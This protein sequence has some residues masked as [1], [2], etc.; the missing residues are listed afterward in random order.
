M[1]CVKVSSFD[2]ENNI[3]TNQNNKIKKIKN[4]LKEIAMFNS[5]IIKTVSN[6]FAVENSLTQIVRANF[7]KFGQFLNKLWSRTH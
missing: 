3:L 5:K 1:V 4:P 2:D 6:I 7:N